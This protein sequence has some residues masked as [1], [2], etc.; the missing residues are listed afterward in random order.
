MA[1][2]VGV[3][4]VRS[5]SGLNV[6]RAIE[7]QNLILILLEHVVHIALGVGGDVDDA[8]G[9]IYKIATL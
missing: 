5:D 4:Q 9:D 2:E 8:A 3:V 1:I 7:N 6:G